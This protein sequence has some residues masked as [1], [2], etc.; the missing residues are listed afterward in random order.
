MHS[1]LTLHY[2]GCVKQLLKSFNILLFGDYGVCTKKL[3]LKQKMRQKLKCFKNVYQCWKAM[4][5]IFFLKVPSE[6]RVIY[7]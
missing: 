7:V 1:K 3:T 4:T 5:N 2:T 6:M